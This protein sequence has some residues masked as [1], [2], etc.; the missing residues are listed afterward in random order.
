MASVRSRGVISF[1]CGAILMFHRALCL[2]VLLPLALSASAALSHAADA[3][4]V[5]KLDPDHARNM[6]KGLELFKSDVRQLL[7]DKCVNC[8]GGDKTRGGLDLTTR[9]ALLVGG[10]EGPAIVVGDAKKS[11]MFKL[12]SHLEKP[13]MPQKEA[14][15]PDAVLA[16][17]EAW[18]NLGAPY[19]GSL[20]EKGTPVAKGPMQVTD[21]DRAFW[22]FAPLKRVEP[23][24]IKNDNWSRTPID[25]FILAKL[26]SKSLVPNGQASPQVL[27]RRAYFD[28]VGL[29]PT[30]E[31]IETFVK[32]WEQESLEFK[33]QSSKL[34][35]TEN[36]EPRTRNS[37]ARLID[38]LLDSP[39]H[40]ERWARHWLDVARFGESFGFEQD[41]DR[42]HAHHYRDFVIKAFN[43]NMPFDQFVRWQIA[44]DEIAPDEPLA[45]MATGFLVAG[46]F[47]TQLT[48]KEFESARYDELDDMAATLG[49]SMIGMT[50]GCARCHDHKFD[51]IPV[52]DYYRLV[53][54]FSTTIRSNVQLELDSGKSGNAVGKWG[55]S[56]APIV[57]ELAKYEAEQL[58]KNFEA[59]AK[60]NPE[61]SLNQPAWLT[62]EV[63]A[64]SHGGATFEKQNDGSLLATGTS[65]ANDKWTFTAKTTQTGITAV[66]LEALAHASMVKGGPGR[67]SNGNFALSVFKVFAKPATGEG[68]ATEVK[69]VSA[70]ATFEQNNSSLSIASSIDGDRVTGWAVDPQ[71]GKNHAAV[72]E[73]E[74]PV[75]DEGGTILTFE[76]EY[77]NNTHHSI[78][79]PRL[80]ISTKPT[81]VAI[82]GD[83]TPQAII[84]LVSAL[85][86][87]G[88]VSKLDAKQKGELLAFYRTMDEDWK[89]LSAKV[90]ASLATKPKP[91]Q[92]TVMIASEGVKPIPHHADGRGFPHFY[93]DVYFLSR[94]DVTKKGEVAPQGFLQVATLSGNSGDK[95]LGAKPEATT[96]SKLSYRRTAL[97]NWIT[98]T[99]DGAGHLLA[100]VIVNRLWQHHFGR[101]LVNTPN[102]FGT[103]GDRPSHPELLDYLATQLINNGWH[104]KP[105]HKL[106]MTSAAYMQTSDFASDKSLADPLNSLVWRQNFRRLEA[107]AIRDSMLAISDQLDETMY[108]PGTLNEAMKRRSIYF[109]IKRSK[110]IPIMTLFD[111]P[112]PLV[113]QGSRPATTIAPQALLFMNNAQVR[114]YAA[115]FAKRIA[116]AAEKSLDDAVAQAYVIA[117]GRK[118]SA[119]EIADNT[120]FIREQ[121][122]SYDSQKKGNS[123]DTALTD[124]CQVMM[125]LNEFVY[126]E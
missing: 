91:Q 126:V 72:F 17:V 74:K 112:D 25:R 23:A 35:A 56:H 83:A 33:V 40:G 61:K 29:P 6:A 69:L 63:D 79:R 71:F 109:F 22:S 36:F 44:G 50:I 10:E 59:W 76:F 65:P 26:Q 84:E 34:N 104:L 111:M 52:A 31:A 120:A 18:I 100:R 42:P 5:A 86:K 51:P 28:L 81:P 116:P 9:E 47:P 103:Q 39:Q 87:A 94:G 12:I 14:K 123:L 58:P 45:S 124:F 110:L 117:L 119:K 73:F 70:K 38:S 75:G 92:T 85:K 48:E 113:S 20:I 77:N 27:I 115:S 13:F 98:D 3:A 43:S 53:S 8:H 66:K 7:I 57:A 30:P 78:G 4:P 11:Y 89:K 46:V 80:S 32:E 19:D 96:N 95:W 55:Q 62:L 64:K 88:D 121:M 1:H 41:Y 16:K 82:E 68:K 93:K 21:R 101:G 114:S 107:E 24:A 49:T 108:G 54:T 37:Y 106:I 60:T 122:A 90:Q 67:A 2:F 105:I 102:D 125:C 15:L 97:A 99:K 118:P